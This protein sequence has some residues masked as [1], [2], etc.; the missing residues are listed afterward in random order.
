MSFN[1]KIQYTYEEIKSIKRRFMY[2]IESK[3]KIDNPKNLIDYWNDYLKHIEKDILDVI[4][5]SMEIESVNN[6]IE[7]ILK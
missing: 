2:Y 6:L 3:D 4:I 5:I 7:Q 1:I